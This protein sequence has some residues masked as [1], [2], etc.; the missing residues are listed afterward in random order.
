MPK[1]YYSSSLLKSKENVYEDK[2][3]GE[4]I[5]VIKGLDSSLLI[6][7]QDCPLRKGLG[8]RAIL[9]YPLPCGWKAG[10]GWAWQTRRLFIALW[11]RKPGVLQDVKGR[12]PVVSEWLRSL[13]SMLSSSL[14]KWPSLF[15][16]YVT[17]KLRKDICPPKEEWKT[18]RETEYFI[19]MAIIE[20]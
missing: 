17:L 5:C 7:F 6:C 18:R 3:R 15:S 4:N 2:T 14:V 10:G 8:I 1:F 20:I 13:S 16:H 11:R 12:Q 19:P 9:A